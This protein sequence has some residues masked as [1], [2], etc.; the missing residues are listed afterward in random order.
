[1]NLDKLYEKLMPPAL[2]WRLE[3][4]QRER[5]ELESF[6]EFYREFVSPGDL[7]FDIGANLGNR[8][9]CFRHMGCKV[10][11]VEPQARCFRRLQKEFGGDSNVHLVNCAV[12]RE[13]GEAT[14]HLSTNHVLASLSTAF[15]ERTKE[16]GRF[17]STWNGTEKV[18]V[19]TL[20]E[21]I[22]EFGDP[23][24]IKIDVEGFEAEVLAGLSRP[25]RAL[26]I[27]WT[28]ELADNTRACLRHLASLGDYEF[29][30]SWG[31]TMR[32]SRPHWR[33]LESMMVV[34]DEFEGESYQFGD[35]YARL[36]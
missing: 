24:F 11:A 18:Q 19:T 35:I 36:R 5:R 10:V 32:F 7:C 22:S 29:N 17:K 12:G 15:M 8:T 20:D 27:E 6:T 26:S 23:A 13:P 33:S 25:V 9:R 1:M 4:K 34:V 3:R 16:S 14:L 31:E 21:L 2:A 30:L 28:P